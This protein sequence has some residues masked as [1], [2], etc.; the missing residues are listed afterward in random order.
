MI[1]SPFLRT[2]PFEDSVKLPFESRLPTRTFLDFNLAIVSL[3]REPWRRVSIKA[4]SL[5]MVPLAHCMSVASVRRVLTALGSRLWAPVI[6]ATPPKISRATE[7]SG[8]PSFLSLD[9]DF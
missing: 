5:S 3:G 6:R 7:A 1:L 8:A 9:L 4:H 2:V